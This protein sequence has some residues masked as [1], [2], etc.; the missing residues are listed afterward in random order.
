MPEDSYKK[1][2]DKMREY[3]VILKIQINVTLE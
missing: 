3:F 2:L 1:S